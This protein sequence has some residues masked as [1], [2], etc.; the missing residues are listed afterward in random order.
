MSLILTCVL[1]AGFLFTPPEGYVLEKVAGPPKRERAAEICATC[2]TTG[3]FMYAV[4]A[5]EREPEKITLTLRQ[6]GKAAE[7]ID[8]PAG[9]TGEETSIKFR[10][11]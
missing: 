6:T 3:T 8:L 11:K 4:G 9:C 2:A 1:T 5:I 7:M 10:A